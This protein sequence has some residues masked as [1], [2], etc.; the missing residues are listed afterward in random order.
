MSDL[1][2]E[3]QDQIAVITLNR[4]AKHNAFDDKILAQMQNLF[5]HAIDNPEIRVILLKAHGKHFSA[6]ADLDWM[7]S[8]IAYNLE[9]NLQDAMILANL[10]ATIYHCPKPTIAVVQGSAYGGGAGLVAACDS[11]IAADNARFCFSEVKLG[12]I[13]AVISPYVIKAIGQRATKALFMSAE[14]LE[15]KRALEL[16]LIQHCVAEKDLLEFSFKYAQSI[17]SNAPLS[18]QAAKK[19]VNYVA[20]QNINDELTLYTAALI[21]EQRIGAEAQK[22]LNAFLNKKTPNWN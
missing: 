18:V 16:N 10:M 4:S 21:A 9:Q 11:A 12:L 7:Q 14:I 3:I 17:A 5:N 2:Y 8:M 20:N 22:G 13:P 6:G 15:A 19:L 1:L